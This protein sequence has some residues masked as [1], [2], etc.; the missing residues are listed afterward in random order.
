MSGRLVQRSRRGLTSQL[1]HRSFFGNPLLENFATSYNG[2]G[3]VPLV[4]NTLIISISS[5]AVGLVI[6]VPAAYLFARHHTR[7]TKN[8][9][10]T[11]LSTRIAPPIALSLPFFIIFT[12]LGLRGTYFAVIVT[13]TIF[14]LAFVVWL[15]EGFF[16]DV[17]V[18]IEMAAQID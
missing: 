7:L 18:E 16:A 3:I 5:V 12:Q 11:V 17:P 4:L 15:L 8:L 2:Q 10:L 9:F 13:H 1:V 6:G 14:N